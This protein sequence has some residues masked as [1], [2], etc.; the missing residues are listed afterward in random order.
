VQNWD[1]RD[2]AVMPKSGWHLNVPVQIGAAAGAETS[3]YLKMGLEGGWYRPLG[4]KWRLGIGGAAEWVLPSGDIQDLPIDLRTFNGGPRSVRSFPEREL[5]PKVG[6]DPFGG[7]F[8]WA[9]NAEVIRKVAGPL[10]AVGF[11]DAG[12]TSGNYVPP[13]EEGVELAAGLGMRLDLPI[14]PVRLEC[15]HNLTRAAG[16][17]SGTWH[18]A[19]G[20]T[21]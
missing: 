11:F 15:G 7:D 10:N 17:P 16:E 4:E 12:G 13:G 8:S 1:Y 3:T 18:F 6:G 14:G 19:I 2:S 5:G 21:F 9:V 20:T